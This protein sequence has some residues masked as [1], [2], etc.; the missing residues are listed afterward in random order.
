[1]L[2]SLIVLS[3]ANP[4]EAGKKVADTAQENNKWLLDCWRYRCDDYGCGCTYFQAT[5]CGE[6]DE[7]GS[8]NKG[9]PV[10]SAV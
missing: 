10:P 1:M 5:W 4:V 8:K 3:V 6:P 7:C 9:P 2:L